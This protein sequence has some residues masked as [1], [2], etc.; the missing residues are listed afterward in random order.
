MSGI[1]LI[2]EGLTWFSCIPAIPDRTRRQGYARAWWR[3]LSGS[4]IPLT[5]RRA[6]M[7]LLLRSTPFRALADQASAISFVEPLTRSSV[8]I[9]ARLSGPTL[10]ALWSAEAKRSGDTALGLART[11][12]AELRALQLQAVAIG[13]GLLVDNR[14]SRSRFSMTHSQVELVGR[15]AH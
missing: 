5:S 8:V 4:I 14:A 3:D 2:Q 11:A 9:R 1:W 6:R 12:P 13:D 10:G 7:S 15:V